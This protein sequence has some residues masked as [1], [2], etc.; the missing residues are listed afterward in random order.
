MSRSD[1]NSKQRPRKKEKLLKIKKMKELRRER[2]RWKLLKKLSIK[3]YKMIS[4]LGKPMVKRYLM[5]RC[6][7]NSMRRSSR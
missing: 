1:T 6:N 5:V 3:R 7:L 4:P 2:S